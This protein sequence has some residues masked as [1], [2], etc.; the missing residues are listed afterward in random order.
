[1][2]ISELSFIAWFDQVETHVYHE[3]DLL[4][5]EM[6]IHDYKAMYEAGMTPRDVLDVFTKEHPWKR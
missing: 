5:T 1:M 2:L 4:L 6:P 3:F